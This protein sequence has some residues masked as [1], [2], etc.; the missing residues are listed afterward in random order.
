MYEDKNTVGIL[1]Y[2][3]F[4]ILLFFFYIMLY[5]NPFLYYSL[6]EYRNIFMTA[7][8]TTTWI[9]FMIS[10]FSDTISFIVNYMPNILLNKAFSVFQGYTFRVDSQKNTTGLEPLTQFKS[11]DTCWQITSQRSHASF[12][13]S[14]DLSQCHSLCS[15]LCY[16]DKWKVMAI[17]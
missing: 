15:N 12:Y 1:P 4:Y 13:S 2:I 11:F 14:R 5:C 16:F 7:E 17:C 8:Y 10:L 3:K 6:H 9:Y